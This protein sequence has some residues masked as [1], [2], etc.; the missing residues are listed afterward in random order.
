MESGHC[1]DYPAP[2]RL[3]LDTDGAP[4]PMGRASADTSGQRFLQREGPALNPQTPKLNPDPNA[5]RRSFDLA[6]NFY[7]MNPCVS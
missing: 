6:L 2:P 7:K 5:Y 1:Q 4:D 3:D